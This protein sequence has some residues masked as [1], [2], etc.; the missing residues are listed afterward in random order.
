MTPPHTLSSSLAALL[1]LAAVLA[2]CAT[3][4]GR[5]AGAASAANPVRVPIHAEGGDAALHNEIR[6]LL[7][8]KIKCGTASYDPATE[9][10]RWPYR[11]E[12]TNTA[13]E[14]SARKYEIHLT[15]LE[16]V[17]ANGLEATFDGKPAGILRPP[18]N[19]DTLRADLHI[20]PGRT[21]SFPCAETVV[22]AR[23][24]NRRNRS[25]LLTVR[26]WYTGDVTI[27]EG[28]TTQ[29]VPVRIDFYV[30]FLVPGPNE[31]AAASTARQV[32]W[33]RVTHF[34]ETCRPVI[35]CESLGRQK[36]TPSE[37]KTPVY[38][39][40]R[41]P[42][43]HVVAGLE[44]RSVVVDGS[45]AD[46]RRTVA[47]TRW[48][49]V[50]R[51]S[52]GPVEVMQHTDGTEQGIAGATPFLL[53]HHKVLSRDLSPGRWIVDLF[54]AD[55]LDPWGADGRVDISVRPKPV[56]ACESG[57]KALSTSFELQ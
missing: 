17:I 51:T 53:V 25:G 45:V 52:P 26:R 55:R 44:K 7:T 21:I 40:S 11:I 38:Q 4:V 36:P 13:S 37:P 12:L 34:C 22:D 33:A 6:D 28:M 42:E 3:H 10:G 39:Q 57:A 20:A 47:C 54:L 30:E 43:L 15:T 18:F 49:R 14:S 32:E 19:L 27:R 31:T 41:H 35:I 56:N 2:G 50:D 5:C 16:R 46:R 48:T 8:V 1:L 9:Q 29:F 24:D 23:G